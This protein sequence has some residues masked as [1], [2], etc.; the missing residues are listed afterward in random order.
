M[1]GSTVAT[2]GAACGWICL[3]SSHTKQ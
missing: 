1:L 3:C 2:E